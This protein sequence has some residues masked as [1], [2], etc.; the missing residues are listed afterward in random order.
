MHTIS[1]SWKRRP[2]WATSPLAR[3][4]LHC[5]AVNHSSSSNR[6]SISQ[7]PSNV[8]MAPTIYVAGTASQGK[9][10]VLN[11]VY[12]ARSHLRAIA[13]SDYAECYWVVWTAW[14]SE[15]IL[16]VQSSDKL[17]MLDFFC[18]RG[19]TNKHLKVQEELL[20]NSKSI[21]IYSSFIRVLMTN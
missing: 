20:H 19:W 16:P 11:T 5:F 3:D 6:L 18:Q 4:V 10:S 1:H 8:F 14:D 9:A 12:R 7:L 15:A 13:S 2:L 17:S 21:P